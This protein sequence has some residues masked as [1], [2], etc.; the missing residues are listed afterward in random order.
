MRVHLTLLLIT[1]AVTAC[2]QQNW[3]Q[4]ARSAQTAHCMKQP[5]SDYDDCNQL[6]HEMSYQDYQKNKEQLNDEKM[7]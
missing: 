2:S 6:P 1:A 7:K 4:G 5:L 3:Y